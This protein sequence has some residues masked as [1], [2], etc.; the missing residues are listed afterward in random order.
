MCDPMGLISP[1]VLEVSGFPGSHKTGVFLGWA[2]AA[3]SCTETILP[4]WNL[5]LIVLKFTFSVV[6]FLQFLPTAL[7]S[8]IISV[9]HPGRI[10]SMLL[11]RFSQPIREHLHDFGHSQVSLAPLKQI[12]IPR[13][14][15]AAVMLSV[16]LDTC[17]HRELDVHLTGSTLWTDSETVRSY[18]HN[19]WK[20]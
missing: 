11:H 15:S 12:L 16:E 1:V 18:V 9:T 5:R 19:E 6:S 20:R 8:Y 10:W 13:L 17:L 14:E 3:R 7:P 2:C 4:G